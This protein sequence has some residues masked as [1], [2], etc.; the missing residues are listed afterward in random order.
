MLYCAVVKP[1]FGCSFGALREC[2]VAQV[3]AARKVIA[4]FDA[5]EHIVE[6]FIGGFREFSSSRMVYHCPRMQPGCR[7]VDITAAGPAV[8]TATFGVFLYPKAPHEVAQG[9]GIGLIA[10]HI[11]IKGQVAEVF[12]Y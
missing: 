2:K 4:D 12:L 6:T 5:L 11:D 7:T 8:D 9:A 10:L 3:N 1:D